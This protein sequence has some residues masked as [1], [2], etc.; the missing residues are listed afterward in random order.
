[1]Q[2]SCTEGFGLEV[3]EAMA[4]GRPVVCSEGAGA[5]DCVRGLEGPS[6]GVPAGDPDALADLIH[7]HYLHRATPQEQAE[8]QGRAAAMTWAKVE[9]QYQEL[10]KTLL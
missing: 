9:E 4:H 3:L 5:V 6:G 8:L 7:W 1:V 2:P 10:W